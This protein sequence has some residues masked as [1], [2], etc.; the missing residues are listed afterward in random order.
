MSEAPTALALQPGGLSVVA[1]GSPVLAGHGHI[2]WLLG[3]Q[4]WMVM[5]TRS[6]QGQKTLLGSHSDLMKSCSRLATGP[7][8]KEEKEKR[9]TIKQTKQTQTNKKKPQQNSRF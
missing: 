6:V 2:C 7:G 9:K 1:T 4:L 3:Q 8:N 5:A